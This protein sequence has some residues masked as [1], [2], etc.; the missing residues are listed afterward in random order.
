MMESCMNIPSC[1]HG[2]DCV[3]RAPR[4][5]NEVI[6]L[7]SQAEWINDSSAIDGP[8]PRNATSRAVAIAICGDSPPRH[9][10][11]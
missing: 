3:S 9:H 2:P 7:R 8:A 6:D 5:P 4:C 1:E 11:S 10:H